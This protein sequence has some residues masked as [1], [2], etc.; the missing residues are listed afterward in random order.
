MSNLSEIANISAVIS[1]VI[2]SGMTI[3]G[4]VDWLISIYPL[5]MRFSEKNYKE[6]QENDLHLKKSKEIEVL[7]GLFE[8]NNTLILKIKLRKVCNFEQVNVCFVERHRNKKFWKLSLWN[9]VNVPKELIS[10]E[11]I[12]DPKVESY[13]DRTGRAFTFKD[14]NRGGV[15][16]FYRPFYL[17]PKGSDLWLE[18]KIKIENRWEGYIKF[19]H[20]LGGRKVGCAHNKINFIYK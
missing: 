20:L 18:M 13:Y 6:A 1:V 7:N 14:A 10:I 5:K 2:L 11:S 15:D 4:F 16:G 17:C 19:E 3:A 12:C 9:W 8:N